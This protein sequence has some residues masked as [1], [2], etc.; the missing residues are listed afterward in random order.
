M[1]T[2]LTLIQP[3]EYNKLFSSYH[4]E[5]KTGKYKHYKL[6]TITK[7]FTSTDSK[8][9]KVFNNIKLKL[10]PNKLSHLVNE[11]KNF[12]YPLLNIIQIWNQLIIIWMN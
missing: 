5:V 4:N 2:N 10:K 7:L 8:I 9:N 3:I 12:P 11:S 6:P 1:K